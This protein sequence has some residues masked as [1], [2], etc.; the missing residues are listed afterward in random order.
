MFWFWFGFFFLNLGY[1]LLNFILALPYCPFC[2]QNNEMDFFLKEII[3]KNI[4]LVFRKKI[5]GLNVTD[6]SS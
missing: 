1:L 6:H 4:F 5:T 3:F 2:L